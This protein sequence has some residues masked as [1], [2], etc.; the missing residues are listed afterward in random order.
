M[1]T[2]C[3]ISAVTLTA[4]VLL[5]GCSSPLLAR[6]DVKNRY[7]YEQKGDMIWEVPTSQKVIALTFDDGPDP[8]ETTQI[9]NVLHDFNAKCTFFA[10]G[11]KI[12]A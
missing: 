12:A 7:Y 1:K 2:S 10:I 6:S 5:L 9:L 4:L 11:K 8:T 3:R